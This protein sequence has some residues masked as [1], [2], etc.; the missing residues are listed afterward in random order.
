M[1]ETRKILIISYQLPPYGG[2]GGRR[3]TKFGKYLIERGYDVHFLTAKVEKK[4][5]KRWETDSESIKDRI[6]FFESHYPSVLKTTPKTFTQK[7]A[8]RFSLGR[9]KNLEKGNCFDPSCMDKV[10]LQKAVST[11]VEKG[12]SKVISTGAPFL[13]LF[14]LAELRSKNSNFKL[15]VDLRDPW[16][17]QDWSYGFPSLS[18]ERKAIEV[19]REKFV[20]EN[21]DKVITVL[22]RMTKDLS[23]LTDTKKIHTIYNGYDPVEYSDKITSSNTGEK[24]KFIVAGNYY[25]ASVHHIKSL[26]KAL[27]ILQKEQGP[28]YAKLQFDFYGSAPNSFH[29]LI[30]DER[31]IADHGFIP[32]EKVAEKLSEADVAMLFLIDGFNYSLSTKFFEYIAMDKPIMM[33]AKEGDSSNFILEN[34]IGWHF[35]EEGAKSIFQEIRNQKEKSQLKLNPEFNKEQFSL[36]KLTDQVEEIIKDLT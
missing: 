18:K 24:I 31:A 26:V 21:A 36:R 32:S 27:A 19:E 15:I 8:Y 34:E 10:P 30:A 2:I 16:T 14:H 11:M 7:I 17:M 25:D 33:F 35:T 5:Q 28:L 3:W 12:F 29:E 4:G 22:P 1:A 23:E 13:Q 9:I 20:M 6:H